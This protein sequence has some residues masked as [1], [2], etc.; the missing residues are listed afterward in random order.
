MSSVPPSQ[1]STSARWA[2]SRS[3]TG[4]MAATRSRTADTGISAR[5]SSVRRAGQPLEEEA[6]TEAGAA[7][8]QFT[9]VGGGAGRAGDVEVGPAAAAGELAQEQGGHDR[10]GLAVGGAVHAAGD[11]GEARGDRGQGA[12]GGVR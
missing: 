1:A 12:G 2:R 3:S 9:V 5:S 7:P 8:G 11:G 10:A 6:G 4:S